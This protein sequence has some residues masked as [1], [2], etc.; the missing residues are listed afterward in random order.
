MRSGS[1]AFSPN[2]GILA[3]AGFDGHVRLWDVDKHRLL[4]RFGGDGVQPVNSLAFGPDGQTIASGGDDGR[5]RIW[6]VQTGRLREPPIKVSDSGVLALA[7]VGDGTLASGNR[8]GSID[9]WGA[10][11]Q[12]LAS[13]IRPQKRAILDLALSADGARV[14]AALDDGTV[15]VW[16]R[17]KGNVLF[18]SPASGPT[19]SRTVDFDRYG[20]LVSSSA[21]GAI[22]IWRAKS[23]SPLGAALPGRVSIQA[24][25][26]G[27][28]DYSILPVLAV[29][30]DSTIL[31]GG[32]D[33]GLLVW[34]A[35]TGKRLAVFGASGAGR[36]TAL[37]FSP[38]GKLLAEAV[39]SDIR[40]WRAEQLPRL[41]PV[42]AAAPV[43][44]GATVDSLDFSRDGLLAA[45]DTNGR[46]HI[47]AAGTPGA[48]P[49]LVG[50]GTDKNNDAGKR[51]VY[52]VAFNP[53][54]TMLA[55][56]GWDGTLRLWRI[57]NAG[58]T[59]P[60]GAPDRMKARGG[61]R[62]LA[63]SPDGRTVAV[64][65][66]DG[67]VSLWDV[68]RRKK[69][70]DTTPSGEALEKVAFA[71]NGHVLVTVGDDGSVRFLDAGTLLP[72]GRPLKRDV[73][74][75]R[76]LVVSPDTSVLATAGDDRTVRLWP[77]ILWPDMPVLTRLV[78][79]LVAG[80]ITNAEWQ[81]ILRR[82]STV[83]AKEPRPDLCAG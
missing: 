42:P 35:R 60:I 7:Y 19:T 9:F 58:D 59:K 70:R 31:V 25:P 61:I 29:S 41:V 24:V 37:A 38:D 40:L 73:G 8:A 79:D 47:W 16:D 44:V 45:G 48:K 51:L 71:A 76:S 75:L 83:A 15:R 50:Y 22:I 1:V 72:L 43:S 3:A 65:S 20:R 11:G 54:G 33:S 56:G 28:P 18:T 55:S 21:D 52:A 74:A 80:G 49:R 46:V 27:S 82:V 57:R 10:H 68:V 32:G 23:S 53:Q 78:C 69:I 63:F 26:R 4:A 2:G 13:R 6:D 14:A 12:K 17:R 77:G 36:A 5:I 66:S 30:P 34:N 81:T 39:G 62:G 64:A 67:G